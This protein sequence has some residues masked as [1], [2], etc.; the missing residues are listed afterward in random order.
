M[1]T[2]TNKE[3]GSINHAI[4]QCTKAISR[5][6]FQSTFFLAIMLAI[7]MFAGVYFYTDNSRQVSYKEALLKIAADTT[8]AA[9]SETLTKLFG[10]DNSSVNL[11][12]YALLI[13]VFGVFT[14][15]Y[16]FHLKEIAKYQHYL[17]G[18][19]RI[20]IAANNSENGFNTE[21]RQSLTNEAF[22]YDTKTPLIGKDK[23]I[24]NPIPGHPSADIG[25]LI[26]N[27]L[28]DSMEIVTKKKN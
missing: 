25:T 16:R 14:S 5:N 8:S 10:S 12:L 22:S 23:K 26:L 24:E 4:E 28:I 3:I 2:D 15:L 18:F 19:M 17:L 1:N 9:K 20:R 6:Q 11:V 7:P 27:K 13:L 21:V